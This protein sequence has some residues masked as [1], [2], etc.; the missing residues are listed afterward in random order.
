[1]LNNHKFIIH[2]IISQIQ[3]NVLWGDSYFK[4]D[5][6]LI[7]DPED[8]DV[9]K[10]MNRKRASYFSSMEF[11][12]INLDTFFV[13]YDGIMKWKF[14]KTVQISHSSYRKALMYIPISYNV[15]TTTSDGLRTFETILTR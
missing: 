14:S 9:V 7:G 10:Y 13:K 12:H 15:D 2:Y 4:S 11:F 6:K 5:V 8:I 1:M 3:N